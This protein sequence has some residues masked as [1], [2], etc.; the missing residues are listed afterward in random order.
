MNTNAATMDPLAATALTPYWSRVQDAGT[1]DRLLGDLAAAALA[2][3]LAARF[4]RQRVD[5]TTQ[6]GCCLRSLI[7]D[8]WI[9][10]L[11]TSSRIDTVVDLGVGLNTRLHRLP[12][13][14][15]H[16]V[17][18]DRPSIIRLREELLPGSNAVRVAADA[19]DTSRWI[20]AVPVESRSSTVVVLEGVLAYQRPADVE[21]FWRRLASHLPASHVIFDS[22]SPLQRVL[23]NRAH[24]RR[25]GRPPYRWAVWRTSTVVTTP[26]P[27]RIVDERG[28]MNSVPIS[29]VGLSVGA[30]LVY[31]LP[32]L[33]RAHRITLA[34]LPM[35]VNR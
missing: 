26:I 15:T 34:R 21:V 16:Y 3:Q 11:A 10:E 32:L 28:L 7:I 20:A 19:L 33:R 2:P 24:D 30:R 12:R 5:G 27:W 8:R 9:A 35:K 13:I 18:V 25:G 31:S 1:D 17:E 29:A 23:G 14:T 22:M 6:V 4:G